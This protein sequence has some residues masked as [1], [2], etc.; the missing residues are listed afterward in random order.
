VRT[1]L[2]AVPQNRA[3][4]PDAWEAA[5][6]KRLERGAWTVVEAF[7]E[8]SAVL[9]MLPPYTLSIGVPMIIGHAAGRV[10]LVV[11]ADF[12]SKSIMSLGVL[13][14]GFRDLELAVKY[15]EEMVP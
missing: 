6:R 10:P 5:A 3:S 14:Y 12:Q 9:A 7:S 8:A 1:I 15:L 13:S 11:I 2:L 4:E